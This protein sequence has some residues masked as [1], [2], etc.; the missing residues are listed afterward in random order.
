M[1]QSNSEVLSAPVSVYLLVDN[2]LLRETLPRLLAKRGGLTI[3][4]VSSYTESTVKKIFAS[5]CAIL[6]MDSL[7]AKQGTTLLA[8]LSERASG[9]G[10]ILFGMDEEIDLFVRFAHLG[11]SAYVLQ[12]ASASEIIAA[13]LAVARGETACPP[14]LCMALGNHL[15]RESRNR[16][17]FSMLAGGVKHS[18][19]R[20]QLEL[21]RLV[22]RG[23][24]NKEIAVQLDLSEFTVKNHLRR[25]M[26]EVATGD[27]HEAVDAVRASGLLP[28]VWFVE[29]EAISGWHDAA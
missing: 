19:T 17:R 25:I 21:I 8:G 1:M 29:F 7:A 24:T 12:E 10:V 15:S 3:A 9:V 13:V 26:K 5:G 2:R 22:E 23:L 4:G 6:L 27:R 11:V 14:R 16:P 20:R 18:L 28:V